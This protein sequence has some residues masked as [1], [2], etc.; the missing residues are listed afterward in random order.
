MNVIKSSYND[1]FDGDATEAEKKFPFLQRGKYA[2][3]IHTMM[4]QIGVFPNEKSFY[5]VTYRTRVRSHHAIVE[6]T[7]SLSVLQSIVK[8]ETC[9]EQWLDENS[10]SKVQQFLKDNGCTYVAY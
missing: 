9:G 8:R 7:N 5:V 3:V 10:L 6:E 1:L 2:K 4:R